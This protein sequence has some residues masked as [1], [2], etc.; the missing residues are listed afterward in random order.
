MGKRWEHSVPLELFESATVGLDES[1]SSVHRSL[2]TNRLK[3]DPRDI[4]NMCAKLQ[5]H[6]NFSITFKRMHDTMTP[7]DD[8]TTVR[9]L[10]L[11]Q[12]R[13]SP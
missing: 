7:Y 4:P 3:T 10:R 9:V 13:W 6:S 1:F 11:A 8:N 2:L 5:P 12:Q